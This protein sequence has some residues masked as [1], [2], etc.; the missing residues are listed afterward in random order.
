LVVFSAHSSPDVG[1]FATTTTGVDLDVRV[2]G[3]CPRRLAQ[4][5]APLLS[6]AGKYPCLFA[7]ATCPVVKGDK[8]MIPEIAQ[9]LAIRYVSS[10]FLVAA[11]HFTCRFGVDVTA[12][13]KGTTFDYNL[14]PFLWQLILKMVLLCLVCLFLL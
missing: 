4:A 6:V 2:E 12:F 9:E 3:I 11:Y 1:Q 7:F 13:T 8:S 10:L 5:M 14:E